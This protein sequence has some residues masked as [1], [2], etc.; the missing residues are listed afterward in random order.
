MITE[1]VDLSCYR[2]GKNVLETV[3]CI[4]DFY[5]MNFFL[6]FSHL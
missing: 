2:S 6:S 4:S 1:A 5:L 3:A